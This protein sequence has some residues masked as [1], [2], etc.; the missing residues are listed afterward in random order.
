[1][2]AVRSVWP[3]SP[4]GDGENPELS[5]ADLERIYG[6]P[7]GRAQPFVQVNFVTS[8]D[9]AVAVDELSAGLSSPPDRRVF[10]LARDLADVVL[11]GAGTAIAENYRGARTNPARTA[12]RERLGRAPVPP[13]AVVTRS[14]RL[15]PAAPLFTD[16][17]VPPIVITTALADTTALAGAEVLVAGDEDVDLAQALALLA[18]RGLRRVDCEGGPRLFGALAAAGLVDQLCLTVAPVLTGGGAGRIAT[19]PPVVP[20]QRLELASI[21]VED[22]YTLLRYRRGDG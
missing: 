11:V 2:A 4:G 6:Y 1:M 12:R 13:I 22:G 19:G 17:R 20:P 8:A 9:G 14:G 5:D 21:L 3:P 10:L 18:E 7:D 15:D 16:T